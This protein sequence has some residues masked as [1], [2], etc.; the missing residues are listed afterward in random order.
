M[1]TY[2]QTTSGIYPAWQVWVNQPTTTGYLMNLP[3]NI[4]TTS[5]TIWDGWMATQTN[6][7]TFN[8]PITNT[9]A[10]YAWTNWQTLNYQPSPNPTPVPTAEEQALAHEAQRLREATYK[11]HTLIGHNREHARAIRRKIAKQT[12]ELLLV[13]CLSEAQRQEWE[14]NKSFTVVTADGLREYRIKR[15][16]AGNVTL[17]KCQTPPTSKHGRAIAPGARFCMHAYHPEGWIPDEDNVLAQ[18][19]LLESPDGEAEF[20]AHANVS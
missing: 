13:E 4:G 19:L 16:M 6:G 3:P 18:K 8:P 5:G 1:L 12:A 17:V 14:T 15:G 10:M 9:G 7:I 2:P 20:L 11:R